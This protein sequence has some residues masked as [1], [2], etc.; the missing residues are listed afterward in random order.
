MVTTGITTGRTSECGGLGTRRTRGGGGEGFESP[1][2]RFYSPVLD[3]SP[4][5]N[6]H[7]PTPLDELWPWVG[8]SGAAGLHPL[9]TSPTAAW[10][11]PVAGPCRSSGPSVVVRQLLGVWEAAWLGRESGKPGLTCTGG[12]GTIFCWPGPGMGS[13]EWVPGQRGG[14]DLSLLLLS[15]H[16]REG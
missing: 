14:S 8:G 11:L 15:P 12:N 9:A 13:G 10:E 4:G 5:C 1:P 16:P 7:T 6:I 3:F 2:G